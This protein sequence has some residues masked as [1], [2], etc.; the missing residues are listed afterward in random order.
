MRVDPIRN[1]CRSEVLGARK[2]ASSATRVAAVL[3]AMMIS[4]VAALTI[5]ASAQPAEIV[6]TE[7]AHVTSLKTTNLRYDEDYS[8]LRNPAKRTGAWWERYKYVPL[9]FSD[10]AY[11]TLGLELRFREEA[12]RQFN[13]GE[14]SVNEYQW[15]RTLPYADLHFGSNL[16]LFGQVI[17]AWVTDKETVGGIDATGAELLQGFADIKLPLVS[18]TDL[19]L[20]G[21]R[22]L[23]SYGTERLISLRYGPNVPRSFDTALAS[24]Q[25]APWRVDALYARPVR[26][27]VG[28]FN[29]RF[30]PDRSLWSIYATGQFSEI[31]SKPGF[32]LYYIGYQNAVAEFNQGRGEELR[33]TIGSRFFG[34]STGWDWNFEGMAQFGHFG[35][36]DI[37]AWSIASD[38]GY[39]FAGVTFSPRFGLRANIISGDRN[40]ND[41]VLETFNPLF[42]KGK[43][44]GEIG[45]IGPYNLI[46]AHPT[47]TLQ[48]DTQW[49]LDLASVF[50]W[51]ESLGDGIYGPGGNLLRRSDDS[52]SRYI[53]TQTD[54]ILGWQPVAWFIAALSYSVFVPGQFIRDTG[55][56]KTAHSWASRRC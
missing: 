55:P 56:Y 17:G 1:V 10:D 14:L 49:T 46:N 25:S 35:S 27:L 7:D 13:W 9:S 41:P 22:Q 52:R 19:T 30:D 6:G 33:H 39:T 36:G 8:Y 54:V 50:Y 26:N 53:G 32:D 42:P 43:Y 31:S 48:L 51:R 38:T 44:F 45:L 28:S 3:A 47:L 2:L 16:R 15:Y 4:A 5:P 23:L 12:Y 37:R 11:L 20:R 18:G 29:D 40:P 24:I 21:G 34:A